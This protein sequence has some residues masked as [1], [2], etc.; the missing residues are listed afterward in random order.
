[1][2]V[3]ERLR[4]AEAAVSQLDTRLAELK[5][6]IALVRLQTIDADHL[7]EALAQFDPLWQVLHPDQRVALVHQVVVSVR[8]EY[9]ADSITVTLRQ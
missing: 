4:E 9:S 3:T 2:S 7:R 1:V 6:Q 8:Y 5:E